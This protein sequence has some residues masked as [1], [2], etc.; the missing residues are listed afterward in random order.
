YRKTGIQRFEIYA[1]GSVVLENG[2]ESQSAPKAL[3][4]LSTRGEIKLRSHN[5]KITQQA[6]PDDPLFRRGQQQRA[7]QSRTAPPATIE[8]TASRDVMSQTSPGPPASQVVTAQFQEV[9]GTA[10]KQG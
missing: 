8:R 6:S 7:G 10:V 5:G 4:R 3:I 1:E 9:A 2:T